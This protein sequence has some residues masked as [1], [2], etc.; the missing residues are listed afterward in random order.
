M[1]R[2]SHL[3]Q[4]LALAET[5]NYRKA[6]EQ[7]GISHSAVSQTIAKMEKV[8]GVELFSRLSNETVPTAYGLRIIEFA[9]AAVNEMDRATRDIQL[10]QNLE[11]GGLVI[12]VDPNVCESVLAPPLANLMNTHPKLKFRVEICAWHQANERL[13]KKVI[14]LYLGMQPDRL[15]GGIHRVD[16]PV[17]PPV[18]VCRSAHPLAGR[19]GLTVSDASR[20]PFIGGDVPDWFLKRILSAYPDEFGSIETLRSIFLTSQDL[21]LLRRLLYLTDAI[22]LK[23]KSL[24]QEGLDTGQLTRLDIEGFPIDSAIPGIIAHLEGHALP[25]SANRLIMEIEQFVLETG[26]PDPDT[27]RNS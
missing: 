6:G 3:R 19:T 15:S 23:P 1:E 8:Y 25:P 22:A 20:Y 5:G 9:E 12:G 17:Q 4:L 10:M 7:L 14:D 26:Q 24:V 27:G 11:S 2:L 21:G 13:Q 18:I 16:L